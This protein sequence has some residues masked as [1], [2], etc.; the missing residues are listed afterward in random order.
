LEQSFQAAQYDQRVGI[1]QRILEALYGIKEK[2]LHGPIAPQQEVR[3]AVNDAENVVC[4]VKRREE[5]F[6]PPASDFCVS[7]ER[8]SEDTLSGTRSPQNNGGMWAIPSLRC[9]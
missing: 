3:T 8:T 6:R 5:C 1:T 7:H 4:E 9:E 2:T